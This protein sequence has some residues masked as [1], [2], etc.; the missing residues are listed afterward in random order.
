MHDNLPASIYKHIN[1]RRVLV[2]A[3]SLG[4]A[5]IACLIDLCVGSSGM[6]LPTIVATLAAGPGGD[7]VNTLIIWSIRLPMTLTCVFVGASL[8]L[9][10]LQVQTIT[11]NPLASPY[12]LGISAGASF[13]AA[14][15]ITLGFT[16]A[17]FQWVGTASL[18]FLFALGVSAAIFF[19]GK[20]KGLN[21]N[22]LILTGIIMNF[23]FTALQQY[24]QYSASAEIAQIISNWSFG[25]LS[26][27]SWASVWVSAAILAGAFFLIFRLS[28]KL[29]ALTAG[30]ERAKSLGIHVEGLRIT[31][32]LLCALL[33]AGA[34]GFIGTVAFVGLV[35]PHCARLLVGED[36][37]FLTPVT[38]ILGSLIMLVAS[39]AAK[40]LSQGSMLP[41][42]I[43]TSIV[44]VPFLFILLMREGKGR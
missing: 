17:G 13:G 19:L 12:T 34:V 41:V 16:I 42:G 20:A 35:A 43:I 23:F 33:I 39:T 32:F 2:L 9:A 4:A 27:S 38:T 18:A 3:V 6:D 40:L 28:W 21:T 15:S 36:Q 37:R 31:V 25:N 7:T 1:R 14:I 30:E 26:R 11:N 8:A 10:G 44:G 24:L 22:T 29:T 5:A